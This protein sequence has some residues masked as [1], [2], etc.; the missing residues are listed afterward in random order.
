MMIIFNKR[1][2]FI[3]MKNL[4]YLIL[5]LSIGLTSC[6]K[7]DNLT[8][9]SKRKYLKK[10]SRQKTIEQVY[11]SENA[12]YADVELDDADYVLEEIPEIDYTET[13]F[14]PTVISE[15][16]VFENN[17][18]LETFTPT[19]AQRIFVQNN[20]RYSKGSTENAEKVLLFLVLLGLG[21]GLLL[22]GLLIQVMGFSDVAVVFYTLA[23]LCVVGI[24]KWVL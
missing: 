10:P 18:I 4:I 8:A 7:L 2:I 24:F 9:F 12:V 23:V 11:P 1:I 16:T 14:T 22:L 15:R 6:G 3:K 20:K 17:K 5:V 19:K 21:L 13:S